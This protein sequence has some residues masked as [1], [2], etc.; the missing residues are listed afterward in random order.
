MEQEVPRSVLIRRRTEPVRVGAPCRRPTPH[1]GPRNSS[2]GS[3][4]LFPRRGATRWPPRSWSARQRGEEEP[5]P[6]ERRPRRRVS[7]PHTA[8]GS[9]QA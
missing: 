6:R 4:A 2:V 3:P 1:H 9:L 5:T 7:V 8:V